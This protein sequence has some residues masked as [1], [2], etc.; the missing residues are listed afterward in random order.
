[1]LGVFVPCKLDFVRAASLDVWIESLES[2]LKLCDQGA[3]PKSWAFQSAQHRNFELPPTP[4]DLADNCTVLT[5][6][7]NRAV[8]PSQHYGIRAKSAT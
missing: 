6:I 8:W 2:V 7:A 4:F 3:N 5:E 1:M